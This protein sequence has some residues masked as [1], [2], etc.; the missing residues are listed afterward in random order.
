MPSATTVDLMLSFVSATT[1]TSCEGIF[2]FVGL[3]TVS[4]VRASNSMS[5]PWTLATAIFAAASARSGYGL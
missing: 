4:R 5:L 2:L 3:S 1:D